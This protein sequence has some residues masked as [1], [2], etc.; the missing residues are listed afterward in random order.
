MTE[1]GLAAP[2]RA[3]EDGP[4]DLGFLPDP[5]RTA[6]TTRAVR[7]SF[8]RSV[9][10]V[11]DALSGA[12]VV[13]GDLQA[14]GGALERNPRPAPQLWA[15]YHDLVQAA[16][17]ERV[18]DASALID[19]LLGR[20]PSV[21]G[22]PGRLRTFSQA[23]LG[24]DTARC[25]AVVD[26]DPAH[27]LGLTGVSEEDLN[28]TAGLLTGA[29]ALLARAD[30]ALLDE[31]DGLGHL[32]L[33]GRGGRE[34][35][36]GA[37]SVFLWGAVV[38]NPDLSQDRVGLA[39]ALAHET[40]H[41]LLFGLT[42]GADLTT[43]DPEALFSSPLRAD[44]RPMEGIVHATYVLARMCLAL[45][46]LRA[47]AADALSSAEIGRLEQKLVRNLSSYD[48]GLSVVDRHARFTPAGAEI[49]TRCRTFMRGVPG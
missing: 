10:R 25:L 37:A 6:A 34:R 12:G 13:C 28:R 29:R 45:Q 35:F 4:L 42:L 44:P 22:E 26:N 9:T 3:T 8:V 36:G 39:E 21:E 20:S 30:P 19:D 49:L 41:A 33:L 15:V 43:N 32:I 1:S 23:H 5:A 31:I 48:A 17:D 24:A 38:L 46:R 18:D 27:P 14:W 16:L 2:P 47:H 7:R 11:L 40:A